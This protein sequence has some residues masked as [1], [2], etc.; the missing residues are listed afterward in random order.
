MALLRTDGKL[1]TWK[2]TGDTADG[3]KLLPTSMTGLSFSDTPMMYSR[4]I[5]QAPILLGFVQ[6]GMAQANPGMEFPL[7]AEDLPPAELVAASLF[8]NLSVSTVDKDGAK[9]YSRTSLPGTELFISTGG[10]SVMVALLLPAVQQAR[11]A[12]RRTQSKNNLKI[13]GLALH[14]YHDD[15]NAFPAGTMPNAALKPEERLSWM[16]AILP[17]VDQAPLY[18]QINTKGAWN[19]GANEALGTTAVD[20]YVHPTIQ[21]EPGSATY[22]GLAGV[23]KAGPTL[24]ARNPKAGVFAYD[25]PRGLRDIT[26]GTSNT[27]MVAESNQ[28]NPWAAGGPGT[29]RPL[30]QAPYIGGVDGIGGVSPGG[31]NVLM[32]DGAVRF[33]SDKVDPTVM[34]AITTI[35]GG[36]IVN[37]F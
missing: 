23:G 25:K 7:K 10:A 13:M 20:V 37:D 3:L 15:F 35:A 26:D 6:M 24:D 32:G 22:V 28:S 31:A 9:S 36:E 4:L 16:A 30:T 19:K 21:A 27:A 34:E 12:A 18:N 1:P 17:Y 33:I 29:I 8:P 5:G 11:E 14:N 2:P